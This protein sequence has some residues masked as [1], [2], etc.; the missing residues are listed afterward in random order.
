MA[1]C[2]LLRN[3]LAEV[4]WRSAISPPADAGT[5]L[6][7]AREFVPVLGFRDAHLLACRCMLGDIRITAIKG[8]RTGS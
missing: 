1:G 4:G 2:P 3:T 6:Y 5:S 7:R 8:D